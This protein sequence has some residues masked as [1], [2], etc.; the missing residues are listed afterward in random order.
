MLQYVIFETFEAV[1]PE[2]EGGPASM[3]GNILLIHP[4]LA[5]CDLWIMCANLLMSANARARLFLASVL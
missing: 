5:L 2:H 3:L 4:F 1:S